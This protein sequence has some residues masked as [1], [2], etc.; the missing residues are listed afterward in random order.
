MKPQIVLQ[1]DETD[2]APVCLASIMKYY[3]LCY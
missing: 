3:L 2:C 1:H